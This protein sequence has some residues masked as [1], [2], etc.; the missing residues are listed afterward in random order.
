MY[1]SINSFSKTLKSSGSKEREKASSLGHH[2]LLRHEQFTMHK[3]T[4]IFCTI[5]KREKNS[6][7]VIQVK[8]YLELLGEYDDK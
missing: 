3:K 1:K 8:I 4:H 6:V 2:P 5:I 7:D